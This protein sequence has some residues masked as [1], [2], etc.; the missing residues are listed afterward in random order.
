MFY[1]QRRSIDHGYLETIDEFE[2]RKEATA[3]Q[4]KYQLA[5]YSAD[6]Y[7]STRCCKAWRDN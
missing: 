6:Y 4:H 7:V 3:M 1:I 2:S 5:D